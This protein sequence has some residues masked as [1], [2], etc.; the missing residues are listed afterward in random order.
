LSIHERLN[1]ILPGRRETIPEKKAALPQD[2]LSVSSE[3]E[4]F[5]TD[6]IALDPSTLV[7]VPGN[8]GKRGLLLI[9]SDA[10]LNYLRK[11]TTEN[12][13]GGL[14]IKALAAENQSY[15]AICEK[16]KRLARG[17]ELG[18]CAAALV[19]YRNA[20]IDWKTGTTPLSEIRDPEV[21]SAKAAAARDRGD[22]KALAAVTA[23]LAELEP[24]NGMR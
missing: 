8:T 19:S 21:L 23:R 13:C 7:A 12:R 6:L 22:P 14:K 16:A 11:G 1:P 17:Y 15:L 24:R 10:L 4:T 9:G 2:A 5:W 20:V 3:C 18:E